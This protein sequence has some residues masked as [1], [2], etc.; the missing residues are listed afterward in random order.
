MKKTK[1]KKNILLPLA[2]VL[3][4]LSVAAMVIALTRPAEPQKG[5]FVPPAFDAAAIFVVKSVV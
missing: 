4:L 1:Q 3:C 2:A 5:A